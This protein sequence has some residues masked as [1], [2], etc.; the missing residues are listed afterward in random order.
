VCHFLNTNH[1]EHHVMSRSR[2][3]LRLLI[4]QNDA[5]QYGAGSATL[6]LLIVIDEKFRYRT[7]VDARLNKQINGKTKNAGRF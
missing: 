3:A 5:A 6:V 1:V 4:H 7:E 2:I